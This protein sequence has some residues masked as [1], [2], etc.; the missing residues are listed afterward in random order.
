MWGQVVLLSIVIKMLIAIGKVET[1]HTP[2]CPFAGQV[3]Y[4]VI[5]TLLS[6]EDQTVFASIS[7]GFALV[8]E[9]GGVSVYRRVGG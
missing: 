2:A 4:V 7:S 8:A 3:Q 6:G 5:P 1:R 9:G